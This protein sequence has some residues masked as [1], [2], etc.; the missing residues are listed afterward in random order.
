MVVSYR[1]GKRNAET[2]NAFVNDLA[3]RL[4]G[5]VELSSDMMPA[6]VEAVRQSFGRAV[7]YGR[8]VKPYQTV[9]ELGRYS[10]PEVVA[11]STNDV[12][13]H[14]V[15]ICTSHVERMNLNV[16]MNPSSPDPVDEWLL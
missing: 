10:P 13:G 8:I 1:I 3:S 12:I 2:T 9:P 5:R 4:K 7:D 11:I 6:Y 16:R 15:Q 14:P